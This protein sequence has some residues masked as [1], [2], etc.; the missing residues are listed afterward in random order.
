MSLREKAH[1]SIRNFRDG[2]MTPLEEDFESRSG[3]PDEDEDD[4][5]ILGG[6]TRLIKPI[7]R[8]D[9]PASILERSPQS[10]NPVVPL[11]LKD[12]DEP[13]HPSVI[14]YLKSFSQPGSS[15]AAALSSLALGITNNDSSSPQ[16]MASYDFPM[17]NAIIGT[18]AYPSPAALSHQNTL[19]RA[20]STYPLSTLDMS[21]PSYFPVFDY[22]GA[23]GT[24]LPQSLY[25]PAETP[26]SDL[27][28]H[29]RS[30]SMDA[31]MGGGAWLD[32]IN[33]LGMV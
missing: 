20:T 19:P 18:S 17:D 1:A 8:S 11:P 27:S 28:S 31:S 29:G 23:T 14:E 25:S 33:Q 26:V 2:K 4:L 3:S 22:G 10:N 30:N 13:M 9:S 12:V 24:R 16:P 32:F 7:D 6:K 15:A 5:S 21:F